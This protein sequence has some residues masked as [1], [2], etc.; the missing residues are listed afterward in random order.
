MVHLIFTWTGPS[1]AVQVDLV[2][3]IHLPVVVVALSLSLSLSLSLCLQEELKS[4]EVQNRAAMFVTGNYVFESTSMTGILGQLKLES[5]EY[6]KEKE[7]RHI[8]QY[9][10]LRG[11][12]RIT[13]DD[14]IPKNRRRNQ[15]SLAF[16]IP[17]ASKEAY[18]ICSFFLSID[19]QGLLS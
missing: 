19:Y 6:A 12:A 5:S 14:V 8:H 11:K 15:H 7:S 17:S 2:Q 3:G 9:K 10:G 16:K 1:P 4:E 13:T 18:R